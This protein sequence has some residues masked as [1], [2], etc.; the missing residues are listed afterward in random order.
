MPVNGVGDAGHVVG[1]TGSC[2]LDGLFVVDLSAGI[3]GGYATKL[4]ADAGAEVLKVE[5][6]SG[7]PLR[8]WSVG[9]GRQDGDDG[10]LF[11]FLA[12]SKRSAVVDLDYPADREFLRSLVMAADA[13]V[14]SPDGVA[15]V[16]AEFQ[17]TALAE[18]APHAPIVSITPFGLNGPWSQRCASDA[19]LQ[20]LSGGLGVRGTPSRAPVLV[21]GRPS[22]WITGMFAAFGLLAS[23]YRSERTGVGELVD[24]SA[25]EAMTLSS[26]PYAFSYNEIAG[27]PWRTERT[28][29]LPD[30]HATAD[31]FVGF[32]VVTGQQWLDFATMVGR[33]DWAEDASLGLLVNRRAR[34]EE[35][36]AHIDS[37]TRE[38]TTAEIVEFAGLLRIP[39]AE[40][41]DGQSVPTLEHFAEQGFYRRDPSGSFL[42]PEVPYRLGGRAQQ[43][44]PEPA[45][46]LGEA[47]YHY[48]DRIANGELPPKTAPATTSDGGLPFEGLRV[49]DFTAF[50]AGPIAGQCLAMLGAD[51]I[52]VES[53]QR[54]DGMRFNTVKLL[55][56]DDWWEWAPLFAGPNTN[57][58][59]VTVD[60]SVESGRD[61]ARRLIARCD[62]V[63]E[64]YSP[65]VFDQWGFDEASLLE[66]RPDLVVVRMPAFGLTGPSRE[67]VGFAQTMEQLSG[68]AF[69]TGYEDG[70]PETPNGICDPI[71]GV[72]A[73]IAVLLGLEHRR[74]TGS[75]LQ[76]ESIMIG[77][78]LNVAA[79]QVIEYSAYGNLVQR[80][81]NRSP[82]AAPQGVYLAADVGVDGSRDSWVV[83]A[84]ESDAQWR[85]LLTVVGAP[86]EAGI[87]WLD[88][89]AASR[90]RVH[91]LL[92]QHLADWCAV[93]S[94]D[95]IVNKLWLRG[96]PAAPV[97]LP[98][99]LDR[100]DQFAAR[101]FIEEVAHPIT[102]TNRHIGFPARFS[103]GPRRIHRHPAPT[104]GQH[105]R[106]VLCGLLGLSDDDYAKLVDT[107]VVGARPA[108][109][110]GW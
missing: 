100:V 97:L 46:V 59:D 67:R 25:L 32:M 24:I 66:L 34:A 103:A 102:G 14:W 89:D 77:G 3:A 109:G 96:V 63:V 35:L 84:A 37:W 7:D 101:E 23:R 74:R 15:G 4:L 60:M 52:H 50:W 1:L 29:N 43:R 11:Q 91:D 45:P 8:R 70:P 58:R 82:W 30:I 18:I 81:G 78:A 86:A 90:S 20:A 28:A 106:D 38:R 64:N 72:H 17:P 53:T 21:G 42:Q 95:E 44:L 71:A 62:V 40:V 31:G 5:P 83:I 33:D 104:L 19:T 75:G 41:G 85:A 76:I 26:T 6:D 93:R 10:A 88:S 36:L 54:P 110:R 49:A 92:D 27:R 22:E 2:P 13:V 51:V 107:A 61:L 57:K 73:A 48:L 65:R 105:N 79:E 94:A 12:A 9:G 87:N 16:T 108:G 68:L 39:V 47:T 98:H 69:V 55:H 99:E 56:D 80:Q